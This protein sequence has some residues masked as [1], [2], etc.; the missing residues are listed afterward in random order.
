[1][2]P[3][4]WIG[5]AFVGLLVIFFMV[6]FFIRDL[7]PTQQQVFR[8]LSAL[9]AGFAGGLLVGQA[10]FAMNITKGQGSTLAVGG[11]TGFALFFAVW[12]GFRQVVPAPPP[13]PPPPPNSFNFTVP[14]GWTFKDAVDSIA[15]SDNAIAKLGGFLDPELN[16]RLRGQELHTKDARE[17]LLV[18]RDLAATGSIRQYTV[19]FVP[20]AYQL[21]VIG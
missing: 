19:T 11:T 18:L 2:T 21:A 1:M 16:S 13:P 14:N 8:F 20:P 9:C 17:A 6:V 7:T 15:K 4:T 3:F 10:T 5:L 12:Y